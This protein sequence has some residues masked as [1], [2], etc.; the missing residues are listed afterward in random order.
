VKITLD[1]NARRMNNRT[2]PKMI[3]N[4]PARRFETTFR[5]KFPNLRKVTTVKALLKALYLVSGTRLVT[6]FVTGL[7]GRRAVEGSHHLSRGVVVIGRVSD[8][9]MCP[10]VSHRVR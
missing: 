6:I 2:I 9:F 4:H 8:I 1:V 10:V 7:I 5:R 3:G